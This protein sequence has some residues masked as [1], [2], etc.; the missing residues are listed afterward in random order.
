MVM[1]GE[2][3]TV[4]GRSISLA[5][6]G[7]AVVVGTSTEAVGA[8][9]WIMSGFENGCGVGAAQTGVVAFEGKGARWRPGL[10]MVFRIG[11]AVVAVSFCG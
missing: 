11:G 10:G 6:G 8:G 2:V 9:G 5:A 1:R 7:M 3:V 4:S